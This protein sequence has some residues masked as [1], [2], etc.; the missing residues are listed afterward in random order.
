VRLPCLLFGVIEAW[1]AG[2]VA[3]PRPAAMW[4]SLLGVSW[5]AL[6]GPTAGLYGWNA[7]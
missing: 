6:S 7:L 3:M 1:Q 2:N 5:T 4:A